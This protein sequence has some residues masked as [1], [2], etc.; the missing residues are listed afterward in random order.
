MNG[1]TLPG[2]IGYY[3]N[4]MEPNKCETCRHS[5]LCRRVVAKDRLHACVQPVVQSV[6]RMDEIFKGEDGK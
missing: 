1:S 6:E 2:C 3:P 5:D 4:P